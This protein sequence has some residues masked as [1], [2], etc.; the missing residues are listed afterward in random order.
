MKPKL[1]NAEIVG[2]DEDTGVMELYLDL[3]AVQNTLAERQMELTHN[4]VSFKSIT[5]KIKLV[6]GNGRENEIF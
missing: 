2:L 5:R 4:D 6:L 3:H 1:K